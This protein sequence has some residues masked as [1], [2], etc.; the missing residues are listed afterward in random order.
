MPTDPLQPLMDALR[1][2]WPQADSTSLATAADQLLRGQSATVGTSTASLTFG[3]AP[4][5][6]GS[7]KGPAHE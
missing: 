1:S 7:G 2:A 6:P 4:P 5:R 3:S